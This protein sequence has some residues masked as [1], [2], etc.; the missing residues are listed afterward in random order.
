MGRHHVILARAVG[1]SGIEPGWDSVEEDAV[2]T[3]SGEA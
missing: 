1:E 3:D 2:T